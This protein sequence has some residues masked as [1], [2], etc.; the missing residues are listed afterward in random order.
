MGIPADV[1]AA[2]RP[3]LAV[4]LLWPMP[5]GWR[6]LHQGALIRH[7]H[8]RAV[9]AGATVRVVALLAGLAALLA[10]FSGV[11]GGSTIGALAML[12]S[13]TAEAALYRPGGPPA[14]ARPAGRR[15]PTRRAR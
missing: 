4:F 7:G 6:R 5:I 15:A 2:A 13:V 14:A 1:A 10:G 11:L 3:T 12:L 9:G 8:S